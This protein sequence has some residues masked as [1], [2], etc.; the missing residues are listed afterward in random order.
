MV[1]NFPAVC[2][3]SI[4]SVVSPGAMSVSI[5]SARMK[6]PWVTSSD[7]SCSFTVSPRFSVIWFGLNSNRLAV[8]VTTRGFSA[9]AARN[10]GVQALIAIRNNKR[11]SHLQFF[12]VSAPCFVFMMWIKSRPSGA[13]ADPGAYLRRLR[14]LLLHLPLPQYPQAFVVR[15]VD[16]VAC[17]IRENAGDPGEAVEPLGICGIA[18][19][20]QANKLSWEV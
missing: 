14:R 6:N 7:F 15:D 3:V 4:T 5:P 9:P 1:V 20:E 2:G 10:R 13:A 16:Q 12:I 17:V 8:I 11:T 19:I 18:Q